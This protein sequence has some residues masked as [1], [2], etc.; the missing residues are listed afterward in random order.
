MTRAPETLPNP[1]ETLADRYDQWFESDEGRRLFSVEVA[2]LRLL[3]QPSGDKRLEIGVGTGRF[4]VALG[5]TYGVDPALPVLRYAAA[6]GIRVTA[7]TA[8]ALP[9]PSATFDHVLL[10]VTICFVRDPVRTLVEAARVLRPGGLLHVGLVP[11]DT[12]WGRLY[13]RKQR[14]GHPFYATARFYT[15]D[16][17]RDMAES[18]GLESCGGAS[19]LPAPPGNPDANMRPPVPGLRRGYGFTGICFRRRSPA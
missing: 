9:F 8:E 19:C 14:E 1:F 13:Q 12:S 7:G 2:C 17:V 18:A 16:E 15:V 4:A 6:R 11:G 10:V 3:P 5:V